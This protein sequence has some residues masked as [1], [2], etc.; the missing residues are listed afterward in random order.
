M[1]R[2]GPVGEVEIA[3]CAPAAFKAAAAI[4]R[5]SREVVFKVVADATAMSAPVAFKAEVDAFSRAAE[6]M[7]A[8]LD[9]VDSRAIVVRCSGM[10]DV[11]AINNSNVPRVK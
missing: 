8:A 6:E 3:V 9:G 2:P 5:A 10:G 1:P 4:T 11:K 7:F